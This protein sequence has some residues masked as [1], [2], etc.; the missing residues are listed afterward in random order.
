MK[1]EKTPLRHP[2]LVHSIM[3]LRPGLR[4]HHDPTKADF[5]VEDFGDGPMLR[6]GSMT[7]PPTQVE[8]DAVTVEQLDAAQRSKAPTA[9]EK[10]AAVG[11]TTDD[12][13]QLL[14]IAK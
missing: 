14:G 4:T 9:V 13:K 1:N 7:D 12:L 5:V 10:L 6:E 2:R 3:A 11:L 8:I